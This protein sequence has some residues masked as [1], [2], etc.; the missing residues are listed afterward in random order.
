MPNPLTLELTDAQR[1]ELEDI[2]DHHRRPYMRERA[3]AVLKVADGVS[4]RETARRRLLRPRWPDTVYDWIR[5]YKAEGVEGLKIRPGRGR[6]AAF[7]PS[8]RGQG[9]GP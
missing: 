7:S 8:V 9:D 2:R 5:R 6:K 4:G 3:A 1:V